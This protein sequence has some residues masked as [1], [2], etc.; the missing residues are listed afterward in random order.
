VEN[1]AL[2][3]LNQKFFSNVKEPHTKLLKS[4]FHSFIKLCNE[5]FGTLNLKI[6]DTTLKELIISFKIFNKYKMMQKITIF[7]SSRIDKNEKIYSLARSF[8]KEAVKNEYMVITGGGPGVMEAGN[9]GAGEKN[10]FGL[11]ILLPQEQTTNP[12]IDKNNRLVYYKY[13]FIRKIFLVK[14]A[15]AFVFFP[16]GFGTFD[17]AFEVL[18]LIQSGKALPLP[19]VMIEPIGFGFWDGFN[20]FIKKYMVKNKFINPF[21]TSLFYVTNDHVDAIN[22]IKNFYKNFHSI[23]FVKNKL[24][25]RLKKLMDEKVIDDIR[26]AYKDILVGEVF[27]GRALKEENNEPELKNLPRLILDFNRK[28]YSRLRSLI[29]FIN[30]NT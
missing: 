7:G 3:I 4:I 24:I 26:K 17:E 20:S 1:H 13:F 18:T 15:C 5:H 2:E 11:N 30:A 21:D 16:G 9:E 8:A 10:S 22:H 19:V 25:I 14:E 29:D 6:T 28:D 12:Y 23:R 27:Q